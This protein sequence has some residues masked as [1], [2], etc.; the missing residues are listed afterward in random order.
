MDHEIRVHE[1]LSHPHVVK[2]IEAFHD[3]SFVYIVMEYC[4]QQVGS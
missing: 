3:E 4:Q 1:S 2:L